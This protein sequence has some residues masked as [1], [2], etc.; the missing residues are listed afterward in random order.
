MRVHNWKAIL[1][2]SAIFVEITALCRCSLQWDASFHLKIASSHGAFDT[3][4]PGHTWVFKPKSILISGNVL[5]VWLVSQTDRQT[6]RPTDHATSLLTVSN[7]YVRSTAMRPKNITQI[8]HLCKY[9]S[10]NTQVVRSTDALTATR[11]PTVAV[12]QSTADGEQYGSVADAVIWNKH[13]TKHTDWHK[14]W[15][16]CRKNAFTYDKTDFN[17]CHLLSIV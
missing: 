4:F 16:N 11:Q 12:V 6:H 9:N 2:I 14:C 1:I 3:W 5:Q 13:D 17:T 8:T 10:Q 7:M 15:L